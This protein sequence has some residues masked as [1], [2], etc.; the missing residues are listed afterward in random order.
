VEK[1]LG[2]AGKPGSGTFL[3]SA[4]HAGIETTWEECK[5]LSAKGNLKRIKPMRKEGM[6][7][8]NAKAREAR[9]KEINRPVGPSLFPAEKFADK[10]G[11]TVRLRLSN[12][13]SRKV[14][15]RVSGDQKGDA[16]P[17][18][19][20][21]GSSKS[22][23]HDTLHLPV[24]WSGRRKRTGQSDRGA[25]ARGSGRGRKVRATGRPGLGGGR[26]VWRAYSIGTFSFV[27]PALCS[28]S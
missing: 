18:L 4:R 17:N 6:L 27:A 12:S 19:L 1:G 16:D 28:R 13:A 24:N 9:R 2:G 22:C 21:F 15:P 10:L 3:L 8:L 23:P 26:L 14:R 25:I 11:G 20:P 5:D 7:A